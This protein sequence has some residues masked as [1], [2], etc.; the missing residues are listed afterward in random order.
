M[1]ILKIQQSNRTR[2]VTTLGLLLI[3]LLARCLHRQ[4][5]AGGKNEHMPVKPMTLELEPTL[6]WGANKRVEEH[7]KGASISKP[8]RLAT[9][10]EGINRARLRQHRLLESAINR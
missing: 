8:M 1:T 2:R 7:T 10:R 9:H 6:R 4:L 3:Q 5:L